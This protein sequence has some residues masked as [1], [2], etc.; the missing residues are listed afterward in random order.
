MKINEFINIVNKRIEKYNIT[1]KYE[2]ADGIDV[3]HDF[4]CIDFNYSIKNNIF[5]I[6]TKKLLI[7]NKV[8][9]LSY[10]EELAIAGR[11]LEI[12]NI[13]A[14]KYGAFE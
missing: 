1:F 3:Y 12:L 11:I 9:I 13:L 8:V 2:P 6:E 10:I 7:V 14:D 5:S 4:K